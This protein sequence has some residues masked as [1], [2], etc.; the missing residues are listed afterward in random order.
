MESSGQTG[1]CG[2][3]GGVQVA[4]KAVNGEGGAIAGE[5]PPGKWVMNPDLR[6]NMEAS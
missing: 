3:G 6:Q 1:H 4:G 2:S 5:R